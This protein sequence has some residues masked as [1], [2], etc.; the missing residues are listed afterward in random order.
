MPKIKSL[1]V[2]NYPN[3]RIENFR[4]GDGNF[5]IVLQSEGKSLR[6]KLGVYCARTLMR[7]ARQIAHKQRLYSDG[8]RETYL[9]LAN[10]SGY[11]PNK[12][13]FESS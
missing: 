3:A 8:E 4:G 6:I 13:E 12:K 11:D 9:R 2:M 10:Q 1:G 5:E 7:L